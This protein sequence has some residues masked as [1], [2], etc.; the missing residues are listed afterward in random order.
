MAVTFTSASGPSTPDEYSTASISRALSA[1]LPEG[2]AFHRVTLLPAFHPETVIVVQR[3]ESEAVVSMSSFE[4]SWW[5]YLAEYQSTEADPEPPTIWSEQAA[6]DAGELTE[7]DTA[8]EDACK[9]RRA[10]GLDGVSVLGEASRGGG[11]INSFEAWSPRAGD[12]ANRFVSSLYDIALERLR[13]SEVTNRLEQLHGYLDRGLPVKISGE[14]PIIYRVFG[15]L[16]S[17]EEAELRS[18]LAAIPTH[19]RVVIDMGGFEGMGTILHPVFVEFMQ[20]VEA[21]VWVESPS[22]TMHLSAIRVPKSQRFANLGDA[23]DHLRQG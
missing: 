2:A 10:I 8:F 21:V 19:E 15:S 5:Y 22:A 12:P 14:H 6:F 23:I 9:S 1:A 16:S 3:T 11:K 7:L 4:R 20:R 18:S 13:S 17:S